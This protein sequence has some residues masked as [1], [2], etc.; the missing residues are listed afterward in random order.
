MAFD[1]QRHFV[2]T[3][4]RYAQIHYMENGLDKEHLVDPCLS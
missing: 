3:H 2:A 1:L 4:G